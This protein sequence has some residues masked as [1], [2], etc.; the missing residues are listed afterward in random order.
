[1]GIGS[2]A[3]VDEGRTMP[4]LQVQGLRQS[5]RVFDLTAGLVRRGYRDD[6]IEA[7]LGGNFKRAL[8]DILCA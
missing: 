5:R 3:A 6:A 1:M 8:N 4:H 7:I 2:D